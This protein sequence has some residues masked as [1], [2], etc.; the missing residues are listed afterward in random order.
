[1][2]PTHHYDTNYDTNYQLAAFRKS[3]GKDLELG[4]SHL[5]DPEAVAT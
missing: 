4:E 3:L 2:P 5:C 1:M